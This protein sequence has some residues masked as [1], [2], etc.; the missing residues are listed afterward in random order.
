[1]AGALAVPGGVRINSQKDSVHDAHSRPI[2]F[3]GGIVVTGD[4][5]NGVAPK[6]QDVLVRGDRI[7][8]IGSD[9]P[10]RDAQ[11]FNCRNKI[12]TV[13][14]I[15]THVH[16]WERLLRYR[17]DALGFLDYLGTITGE[18]LSRMTAQDIALGE[19]AEALA[20]LDAGVGTMVSW[21]H[22]VR[23]RDDAL[24]V[25]RRL[26]QA[27]G[28]T[29]FMHGYNS[30]AFATANP[31]PNLPDVLTTFREAQRLRY[32]PGGGGILKAGL[33]VVGPEFT[34]DLSQITGQVRWLDD[35]NRKLGT[36][37]L[38]SLHDGIPGPHDA[39]PGVKLMADAGLLRR[40]QLHVHGVVLTDEELG[41]L[42]KAGS[43]LSLSPAIDA[44][45]FGGVLAHDRA[46]RAGVLP[47]VSSDD[48]AIGGFTLRDH[49]RAL[50]TAQHQTATPAQQPL[51]TDEDALATVTRNAAVAL[52]L[53]RMGVLRM[54][55]QAD[56]MLIDARR[57]DVGPV[58]AAT[59]VGAV[60]AAPAA[61]I[62]HLMLGG[63]WRKYDGRLTGVDVDRMLD[64]VIAAIQRITTR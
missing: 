46:A 64:D 16:G 42:A 62:S 47:A 8:A 15:D 51:M 2:L 45:V 13:P 43:G 17:A 19:Y 59:A 21:C 11:V 9:L 4:E 10:R 57:L 33:A 5:R 50:M 23:T 53:E 26:Y 48:A 38:L 37:N 31:G 36:D 24:T 7:E 58:M 49:V 54:G 61:A 63:R 14:W 27:G 22:A 32:N 30:L 18:D 12:V 52:G 3:Q 20:G 60:L 41:A 1:M 56:I 29:V 35:V 44:R 40:N 25:L 39:R 55:Y 28:W 6:R 34:P